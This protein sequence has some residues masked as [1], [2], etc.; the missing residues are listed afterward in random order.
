MCELGQLGGG[1]GHH[2][3]QVAR[4]V[5]AG[6]ESPRDGVGKTPKKPHKHLVR[7]LKSQQVWRASCHTGMGG[8]GR[9]N[10]FG[11]QPCG[12]SGRVQAFVAVLIAK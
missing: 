12:V 2:S 9:F 8:D 11:R 5:G 1:L 4:P 3:E 10:D 7:D 6:V